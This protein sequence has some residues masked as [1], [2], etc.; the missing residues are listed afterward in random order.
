MKN[1]KWLAELLGLVMVLSLAVQ[2]ASWAKERTNDFSREELAQMLAP[3]ALYPDVLLSQVLMGAT[4]P[5]EIV[6][7]ERWVK[8]NPLLKGD[9]LDEALRDQ[10][11]DASVKSLCHVPAV[12]GLMSERLEETSRL[13]D[14]FL[15]QERQVMETVQD[16]RLRAMR[17]GNLKSDEKQ[18]VTVAPDG[19]IVI[20][21]ADPET[22]YVP[23]YN[24][25]YVYGSWWYPAWP[26]WYWGPHEVVGTGIFFWP[27]FFF[28]FGIGYWSHIDWHQHTIVIDARRRPG[29][30]RPD[31]DWDSRQGG[32]RHEPRHR[33][34]V[35]YR[36]PAIAERFAQPQERVRRA[37]EQTARVR[38]RGPLT[39][40]GT[41]SVDT[42]GRGLAGTEAKSAERRREGTPQAPA[43]VAGSGGG[44][45]RRSRAIA[46]RPATEAVQ[47]TA[48]PTPRAE[49]VQPAPESR[50]R[51]SEVRRETSRTRE[52]APNRG[53]ASGVARD[54]GYERRGGVARES[55][56]SAPRESGG[57]TA[58]ERAVRERGGRR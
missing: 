20:E 46:A 36:S 15:G 3:V 26:P 38:V 4:Y 1:L 8:R 29:F 32:W 58:D 24:T 21:P 22:V 9:N 40:G 5:L 14:A 27:D 43:P 18:K 54:S 50:V 19:T 42:A 16:L 37:E 41:T 23:Y 44:Q 33:R 10:D 13:G 11:W 25:R 52:V 56:S 12:L 45:E 28:G 7:A 55:R 47:P 31:Y 53:V 57:A 39:A 49:A 2:P 51:E 35:V 30:F 34:G 48:E 6:E 17:E